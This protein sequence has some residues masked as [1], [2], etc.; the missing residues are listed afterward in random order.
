MKKN[1]SNIQKK[2]KTTTV[3]NAEKKVAIPAA[4]PEEP[5][6]VE[7]VEAETVETEKSTE[8]NVS[9]ITTKN[10]TGSTSSK[11]DANHRVALLDLA[12]SIFR[13]DPNAEQRFTVE[14][15]EN[16]NA[17]VA[18]GVVAS[19]ADEAVYGDSTFSA[20]LKGTMYPQLVVTAKD[21]GIT[22]P[23]IKAL[24]TNKDGDVQIESKQIKVSKQAK[25][26]LAEEHAIEEEKPEL[27]PVKVAQMDE[28]AL[29]KALNYLLIV[30]PKKTNIKTT[31]VNVVDFMREYRMNLADKAENAADAKLK[32]DNYTVD[33]WLMDAFSYVKPTFLLHGIGRGLCSMVS[34][35]KGPVSAFCILR[36]SL[37]NP[38]D[39][40]VVWDDQSIADGV[41]AIVYLVAKNAIDDEQKNLDALD[42]KA[43]D[44]KDVSAKYQASIKHY[45]D[46]LNWLGTPDADYIS[47]FLKRVDEDK[48]PFAIK[49]MGRLADAYYPGKARGGFKN[50]DYNIVQHMGIICNMFKDELSKDETYMEANLSDLV[51]YT[52][53][54]IREMRKAEA[55]AAA[56]E[57]KEET[58]N[59]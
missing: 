3:K 56:A 54:E 51:A 40:T 5:T 44:Y 29:R 23:N 1:N 21:M 17:I 14:I 53:D 34:L 27:D 47:G 4:A 28:D 38:D 11:L 26:K 42:K 55:E 8:V 35:E 50:Y 31:L 10:M 22:L 59:A 41:K 7:T 48:D 43:K 33:Q 19:L 16:V 13:R 25:E 12:D 6:V 58:K 18:A 30:G 46:I 57:K 36:K 2:S 52:E 32:Y 24:P 20:V 49:L 39:K 9:Q 37:T 15:R 45:Q